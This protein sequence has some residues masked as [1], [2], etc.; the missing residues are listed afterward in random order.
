MDHFIKEFKKW[1]SSKVLWSK[2]FYESS[3]N[4]VPFRVLTHLR[5]IELIHFLNHS[6]TQIVV[7]TEFVHFL[8]HFIKGVS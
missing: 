2:F 1:T 7:E 8:H 6:Y 4:L 5:K 3:R